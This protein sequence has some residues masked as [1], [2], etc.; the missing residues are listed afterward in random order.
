MH[1]PDEDDFPYSSDDPSL[2]TPADGPPPANLTA[3][4]YEDLKSSLRLVTGATLRGSEAYLLRLRRLQKAV[5]DST[6]PG[7]M[8]I[9]DG[10]LE[11]RGTGEGRD[12]FGALDGS[13][14]IPGHKRGKRQQT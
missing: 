12:S 6:S 3:Q 5:N 11:R 8:V 9:D 1:K 7:T 13:R 4:Q 14:S 2:A 10:I